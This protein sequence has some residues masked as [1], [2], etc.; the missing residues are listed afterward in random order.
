MNFSCG[1]TGFTQ[2][3]VNTRYFE[4]NFK[5]KKKSNKCCIKLEVLWR[6]GK[7]NAKFF[8][9]LLQLIKS[10]FEQDTRSFKLQKN[11]NSWS[12]SSGSYSHQ[13]SRNVGRQ[14]LFNSI[15]NKLFTILQAVHCILSDPCI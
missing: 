1:V 9:D 4:P 10:K 13:N 14:W 11:H 6:N 3:H 8:T 5:Q 12:L 2:N 7:R 15:L